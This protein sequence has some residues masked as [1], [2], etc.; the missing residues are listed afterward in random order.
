VSVAV[1]VEMRVRE[2]LRTLDVDP[3]RDPGA[4]RTLV[5]RVVGEVASESFTE[6]VNIAE[7]SRQVQHAIAGFGPLQQFFDD[8]TVEEVWINE[9]GRVFV[10]RSGRSELTPVILTEHEVRDLVERMLRWSGRRLDISTPFVDAMLPDGSRLHVVIPDITREHWSVNVRR[11]IVRPAHVFA[12]VELGTL[13]EQAAHFLAAAVVSGLNIVIAGG[14]QAGKTT[15]L[16]ALLGCVPARE[17]IVSCEEVFEVHL[18][19]PDWVALQTRDASLEGTG[20]VPLRRLVKEALRMRPTRLVVGE[21]RQAES[22]DLLIAMNSGMPAM[23]TVHANSAR[24]AVTKLCTLPLLAG[25]NI[26]ADFVVPTVAGCVDLV[27]HVATRHDGSRRVQE[28]VGLPG[29]SEDGV[30]EIADLFTDRGTGLIRGNGFPPHAERFQ[31]AGFD[32]PD[33]L[34]NA[35]PVT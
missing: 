35:Q 12:M 27:I 3:M 15:M 20:A 30:I 8:P 11:F 14:T 7:V 1:A 13:S 10:A 25:A 16:N 9:P 19:H 26:A 2:A 34:A 21:V 29:R 23:A 28:I 6:P 31:R 17:R 4:I 33:L 24:E 18:E 22:L 5:D 32:L